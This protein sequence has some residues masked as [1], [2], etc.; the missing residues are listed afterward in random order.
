MKFLIIGYVYG[1]PGLQALEYF[2]PQLKE[3]HSPHFV[4]VNAE[5]AANGR[6]INQYINLSCL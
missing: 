5:N 3:K 1:K 6:G 4:I 2:L